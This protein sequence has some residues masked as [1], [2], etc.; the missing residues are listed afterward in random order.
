[1]SC[2]KDVVTKFSHGRFLVERACKRTFSLAKEF[3]MVAT[4]DGLLG[5]RLMRC[6][7]I[8][9]CRLVGKRW[10]AVLNEIL[11]YGECRRGCRS[12]DVCFCNGRSLGD[13][14]KSDVEAP[15]GLPVI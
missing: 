13:A 12:I 5:P 9:H 2:T 15:A 4:A 8:P 7:L 11:T 10:A 3:M 6:A 1:M 14:E